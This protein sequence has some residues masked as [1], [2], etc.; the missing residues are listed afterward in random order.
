MDMMVKIEN[1]L[2]CS[3]HDRS[4]RATAHD[5]RLPPDAAE[6]AYHGSRASCRAD[7]RH[8]RRRH[9]IYPSLASQARAHGLRTPRE[10]VVTRSCA[11]YKR[12]IACSKQ[13]RQPNGTARATSRSPQAAPLQLCCSASISWMTSSRQQH[14]SEDTRRGD[15]VR[16]VAASSS[17]TVSVGN[18]QAHDVTTDSSSPHEAACSMCLTASWVTASSATF[19][20]RPKGGCYILGSARRG[21]GEFGVHEVTGDHFILGMA[22]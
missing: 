21:S 16:R 2:S 4:A 1:T 15:E 10:S 18:A 9:P 20:Q 11:E 14:A 13:P 12:A 6:Q 5:G 17:R 3:I 7:T 22:R 19:F 8:L